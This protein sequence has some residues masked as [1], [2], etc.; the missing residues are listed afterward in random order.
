MS[1]KKVDHLELISDLAGRMSGNSV[2]IKNCCVTLVSVFLAMASQNRG[3][4]TTYVAFFPL[5]ILWILDGHYS[6]NETLANKLYDDVR[7]RPDEMI[8]YDLNLD[9]VN[10]NGMTWLTSLFSPT[11]V[12]FYGSM[13]LGI[14]MVDWAID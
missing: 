3:M 1:E 6:L 11:L 2:L 8:D 12:V 13:I 9:R 10:R 14:F 5:V 7:L 4:L